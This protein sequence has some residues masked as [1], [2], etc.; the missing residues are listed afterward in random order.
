[1]GHDACGCPSSLALMATRESSRREGLEGESPEQQAE[2]TAN[3]NY[4]ELQAEVIGTVR[5]KLRSRNMSLDDSDL[6][7]AYCQAWHAVCQTI[8]HGTI[9]SNLTGMLVEITWRRAVDTYREL[10]PSQRAD[11]EIDTKASDLDID[12]QI[13]DEAKLKHFFVRVRTRLNAR[14]CEAVSLCLIHGYQRPEAAELMGL[15]R[16][17]MEKLMDGATRKIGVIVAS[18]NARGC[19]E[20]EWT[21]LMQDYALGL[22]ADDS[23][24]YPRATAHVHECEACRRYVHGLRGLAAILPPPIVLLGPAAAAGHGLNVLAH[25]KGIFAHIKD[26]LGQGH[27]AVG[28]GTAGAAGSAS[29]GGLAGSIN[30]S[31]IVKGVAVVI[32]GVAAIGLS[33]HHAAKPHHHQRPQPP[34][35]QTP[36]PYGGVHE[37]AAETHPTSTLARTLSEGGR[38]RSPR[39]NHATH[40]QTHHLT[41]AVSDPL[42]ESR[43]VPPETS[44]DH[45]RPPTYSKP[46]THTTPCHRSEFGIEC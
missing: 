7:E 35:A 29:A 38:Q 4:H 5:G 1:M 19:G 45:S 32:A 21:R 6:E 13:D 17:Q 34:P 16:P 18:M 24:D 33:T 30:T 26:F 15:E 9:V 40:R 36:S 27:G 44:L 2:R 25:L 3:A 14:E 43:K 20:E 37:A 41:T 10:R 23:R 46:A 39:K 42:V 22:L 31:T 28:A 12:Q 11:V 8:R